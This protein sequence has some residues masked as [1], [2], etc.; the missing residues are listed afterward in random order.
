MNSKM[1]SYKQFSTIELFIACVQ[2]A[3]T[4]KL[5]KMRSAGTRMHFRKYTW[6]WEEGSETPK[7]N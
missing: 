2:E 4:P 3:E 1:S 7:Q 5:V 6:E